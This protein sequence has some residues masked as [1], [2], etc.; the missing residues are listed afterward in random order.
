MLSFNALALCR[1]REK[2]KLEEAREIDQSRVESLESIARVA[3]DHARP[4]MCDVCGSAL[5][6]VDGLLCPSKQHFICNECLDGWVRSECVPADGHLAKDGG[7]IWCPLKPGPGGNGC[8]SQRELL[9]KVRRACDCVT[10]DM[11]RCLHICKR[12]S[13]PRCRVQ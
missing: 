12:R 5:K 7:R 2:L 3:H 13:V 9:P 11:N 8:N 6:S 1:V 10:D 4:A